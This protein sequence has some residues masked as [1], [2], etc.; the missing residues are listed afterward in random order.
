MKLVTGNLNYSSWSVRAWLALKFCGIE[1]EHQTIPLF[2]HGHRET[3]LKSSPTGRVPVLEDQ[4]LIVWD[5]LSILEHLHEQSLGKRLYPGEP[6]L[7]AVARSMICEMHSSFTAIRSTMPMNIRARNKKPGSH[8]D[9]SAEIARMEELWGTS[10]S[11]SSSQGSGL[12]GELAAVDMFY[13]PIAFRFRTYNVNLNQ[14]SRAY[15]NAL[16]DWPLV[17]ALEEIAVAEPWTIGFIDE[18]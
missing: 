9:L 10:R 11:A 17:K 15:M 6:S 3:M 13:V 18:V 12:F 8:P 4:G 1:F 16:L 2:E 7:R 14:R 5:S